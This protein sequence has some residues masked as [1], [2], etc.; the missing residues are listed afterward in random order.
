MDF[1]QLTLKNWVSNIIQSQFV[2]NA[3]EN[4]HTS[5]RYRLTLWDGRSKYFT[6]LVEFFI[7]DFICTHGTRMNLLEFKH[8]WG[9][10]KM[11]K[12]I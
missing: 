3:F 9:Q 4:S 12:Y 8:K 2:M 6:F 10:E 7:V 5:F 11:A 1:V